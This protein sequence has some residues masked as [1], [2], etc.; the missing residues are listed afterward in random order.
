MGGLADLSAFWGRDSGG[1]TSALVKGEKMNEAIGTSNPWKTRVTV[2]IAVL[3]LLVVAL[4]SMVQPAPTTDAASTPA[5]QPG[6]HS[7]VHSGVHP[8]R[9]GGSGFAEGSYVERHAEA[10]AGHQQ[11]GPH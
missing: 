5:V 4:I 11:G 6:V 1:V 7:V 3:V 9:P 8:K 2:L 10:V